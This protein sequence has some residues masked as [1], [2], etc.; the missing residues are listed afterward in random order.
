MRFFLILTVL[1]A[2]NG[3]AGAQIPL[4]I[5]TQAVPAALDSG[6]RSNPLLETA[7]VWSDVVTILGAATLQLEFTV[8]ELGSDEDR[9]FVTSLL[10]GDRM[11]LSRFTLRQWS[12]RTAWFNGSSV[13]V[14]LVL[15]PGSTGRITMGQVQAGAPDQSLFEEGNPGPCSY[16]TTGDPRVLSSDSRVCRLVGGGTCTGW[17]IDDQGTILTAGHCQVALVTAQFNVPSSDSMGNQVAPPV[18]DQYPVLI[19]TQQ[20]SPPPYSMPNDWSVVKLGLNSLMQSASTRQ[21]S[22][23]FLHNTTPAVGAQIRKVGHGSDA[24]PDC[25]RNAAQQTAAGPVTSATSDVIYF[26][27]QTQSGDSGGVA[28][29]VASGLAV[30]IIDVCTG[31]ASNCGAGAVAVTYAPLANAIASVTGCPRLTL[32]NGVAQNTCGVQTQFSLSPGS[33]AW[34]VVAV[35]SASDWDL[36]V[37]SS[38]SA[39]GGD[40]TDFVVSNGHLGTAAPTTGTAFRYSGS[41]EAA[42][43]HRVGQSL[44]IG[45]PQTTTAPEQQA[46]RVFEFNVTTAGTYWLSLQSHASLQW[47]LFAPGTNASW[48][49][50]SSAMTNGAGNSAV[51]ALALGVGRHC[52]VIS[53]PGG[54]GFLNPNSLTVTV[55]DRPPLALVDGTVVSTTPVARALTFAPVS[56]RWNLVGVSSN[57]NWDIRTS[58]TPASAGFGISDYL[59][60]DGRAGPIPAPNVLAS[61]TGGE[62]GSVVFATGLPFGTTDIQ[63][64][65]L[66]A[67][68]GLKILEF[69]VTTVGPR[70]VLISGDPGLAWRLYR[71]DS[72]MFGANWKLPDSH[73]AAGV[74]GGPSVLNVSFPV[75][76]WYCLVVTATGTLPT[77][78]RSFYPAICPSNASLNLGQTSAAATLVNPCQPFSITPQGNYWNVVG[79]HSASDWDVGIGP[80]NST[81]EGTGDTG[82]VVANGNEG[83]ITPTYGAFTRFSGNDSG[84]GHHAVVGGLSVGTSNAT[85]GS[86]QVVIG[87]EIFVSEERPWNFSVTGTAGFAYAVFKRSVGN[88]GWVELLN[89]N[90]TRSVGAAPV[91]A[92]TMP[93]GYSFLVIYRTTAIGTATGSFTL[94]VEPTPNPLPVLASVTPSSVQSLSAATPV[95]LNGS[96]FI[97]ESVARWNGTSL[98]TTYQSSSQLTV[99]LPSMLLMSG[100]IAELFV[101]SPAPGGGISNNIAFTITNP[102][103]TLASISPNVLVAGSGATVI[104]ANGSGFRSDSAIRFNGTPIPTTFVSPTQLT[105][106]VSAS[107]L[108]SGAVNNISVSSPSPGGGTT[109]NATLTVNNALPVLTSIT[110]TSVVAGAGNTVVMAIGS[111]FTPTSVILRNG[112]PMS[113]S[114]QSPTSLSATLPATSLTAPGTSFSFSVTS[115]APGGGTSAART[116]IVNYPVPQATSLTPNTLLAGTPGG[117]INVNGT[118]FFAQT[119]VRI[120]GQATTA[121]LVSATQLQALIP[122][123]SRA[124]PGVVT[125]SVVNPAPGGGSGTSQPLTILGPS[126]SGVTP[127]TLALQANGAPATTV[128]VSGTNFHSASI[129]HFNGIAAATGFVNGTTLT[130]SLV[131]GQILQAQRHGGITVNVANS[132]SAVSNT[133]VI[134]VG[135]PASANQGTIRRQPLDPSAGQGYASVLEGGAGNQFFSLYVDLGNV[136]PVLNFPSPTENLA[137]A[138]TPYA[139][140]AGP[141]I[142]LIESF[143]LF[144]P[145]APV[146]LNPQGN[147][148]LPGFSMPSPALNLDLTVQMLYLDPAAP[149]GFRLSWARWPDRL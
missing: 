24:T 7:S 121:I 99:V 25:T 2:W 15:A 62:S 87:R 118:G 40:A 63:Y 64:R 42:I 143:G 69:E 76:G 124:T 37:G 94:V 13:V 106:S 8:A 47:H 138:V 146:A 79:V 74:V 86:N 59:L 132:E 70:D 116:F 98:A 80:V 122:S 52:L 119:E 130:A 123:P 125:V 147:F 97:S 68:E 48:R 27:T 81:Q 66:A 34:N 17:L 41:A 33:S 113:T 103:P 54:L 50:R 102:T 145:A 49:T 20:A 134:K 56:S 141:L 71:P 61:T 88:S 114:F 137:L 67:G 21:G 43:E 14:E 77:A 75:T 126:I 112:L 26:D 91:I 129:V 117:F 107:L 10:D 131:P 139:G 51:T 96:G 22:W 142:P 32:A 4:P 28:F 5:L 23:F 93:V 90:F 127:A 38:A 78:S 39:L 95:T 19:A 105:G 31:G 16:C 57:G 55:L 148:T 72:A 115:P 65:S 149:S 144:A 60:V 53:K 136:A 45:V 3:V 104:T 140:S 11:E 35:A 85:M 92:E 133:R 6:P 109:N 128:T 84:L 29:D 135:T 100:G 111:G 83:V 101:S 110:P 73:L 36:Q 82:L 1:V 9:V 44:T 89:A 18:A 30:G 120:N 58:T 108:A 12:N 46:L